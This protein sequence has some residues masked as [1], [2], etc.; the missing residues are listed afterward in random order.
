MEALKKDWKNLKTLER[1]AALR[2]W[3]AAHRGNLTMESAMALLSWTHMTPFTLRNAL[4]APMIGAPEREPP[5]EV[6]EA[7]RARFKLLLAEGAKSGGA[8]SRVRAEFG[9][10]SAAA[11]LALAGLLKKDPQSVLKIPRGIEGAACLRHMERL[12]PGEWPNANWVMRLG[13]V[14]AYLLVEGASLE[15]LGEMTGES[16]EILKAFW[17]CRG[18]HRTVLQLVTERVLA[19]E[20]AIAVY[21]NQERWQLASVPEMVQALKELYGTLAKAHPLSTQEILEFFS[22]RTRKQRRL[23]GR[24]LSRLKMN[25]IYR[26]DLNSPYAEECPGYSSD[27]LL[28][29]TLGISDADIKALHDL[30]LA[31]GV[32]DPH[33]L[34][35]MTATG[36]TAWV[37]PRC[38]IPVALPRPSAISSKTEKAG[39][40]ALQ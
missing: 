28:K 36:S 31:H 32:L 27:L 12:I 15:R 1:F 2:K 25:G 6:I 13:I 24:A 37:D 19:V 18:M 8:F 38:L 7:C 3:F 34:P 20:A 10:S 5:A 40:V 14:D 23:E 21:K 30:R 4:S 39:A 26:V 16:E 9:L 29:C 11:R 22:I 17:A 35:L 33:L